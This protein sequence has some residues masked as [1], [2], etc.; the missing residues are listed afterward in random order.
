MPNS[1]GLINCLLQPGL[2]HYLPLKSMRA[3]SF[4]LIKFYGTQTVPSPGTES[5][6]LL[7]NALV[8]MVYATP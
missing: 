7:A 4:Q 1:D 3:N 6:G 2:L 8:V 5:I